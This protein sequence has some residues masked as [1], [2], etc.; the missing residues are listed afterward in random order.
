MVTVALFLVKNEENGSA[1]F[2]KKRVP[3]PFPRLFINL[4]K[5]ELSFSILLEA[6]APMS[7]LCITIRGDL[8]L[9][10]RDESSRA[11]RN[12]ANSDF[13][14][15]WQPKF[16]SWSD[17]SG[18]FLRV[19]LSTFLVYWGRG[20]CAHQTPAVRGPGEGGLRSLGSWEAIWE[21]T[22]SVPQWTGALGSLLLA[23]RTSLYPLSLVPCPV[24]WRH[25][26]TRVT[27]HMRR[28]RTS[29][30]SLSG[31]SLLSREEGWVLDFRCRLLS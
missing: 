3:A 22:P 14:E 10:T 4:E 28:N 29:S 30:F 2:T 12:L 26:F 21:A 27:P 23:R 6:G 24:S 13:D 15:R 19:T 9:R 25:T 1:V 11:D 5:C 8:A 16:A 7:P 18:C 20:G 17:F 31:L